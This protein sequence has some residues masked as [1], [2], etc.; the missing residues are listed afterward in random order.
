V[1]RAQLLIE[2]VLSADLETRNKIKEEQLK[3]ARELRS[4]NL[5]TNFYII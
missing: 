5:G 2:R 4:D 3:A 1:I